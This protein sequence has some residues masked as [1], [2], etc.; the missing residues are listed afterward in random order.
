MKVQAQ[1]HWRWIVSL[2]RK[3][4][5]GSIQDCLC[6]YRWDEPEQGRKGVLKDKKCWWFSQSPSSLP[7]SSHPLQ[8]DYCNPEYFTLKWSAMGVSFDEE[9][10]GNRILL[11]WPF[12]VLDHCPGGT[13]HKMSCSNLNLQ[14]EAECLE[15]LSPW[16]CSRTE[17]QP[18]AG[19]ESFSSLLLQWNNPSP[20][21]C[22][23]GVSWEWSAPSRK[24]RTGCQGQEGV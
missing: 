10:H 9:P 3:E 1:P 4:S 15:V 16:S 2:D 17:V 20:Q 21:H 18:E 14:W 6:L 24:L 19:D 23:L 13:G 12:P 8:A 11:V 7:S 5:S 22:N